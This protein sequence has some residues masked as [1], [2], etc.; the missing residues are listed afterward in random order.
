MVAMSGIYVGHKRCDLTHEPSQSKIST[1]APKD[2]GGEGSLF[3]PTDLLGASLG[4]CMLTTMAIG[5]EKHGLEAN[6]K[7]AEFHVTKEMSTTPPRR[8]AQLSVKIRMPQSID[9]KLRD[10]LIAYANGCPVK[11][12]LHPDI[13][14][15]VE[16]VW[17]LEI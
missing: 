11:K 13:Q 16:F 8:V 2:N 9:P 15:P 3:S 5:A 17:D 12:S 4:S 1:D 14:I 10:R 7:G 6:I